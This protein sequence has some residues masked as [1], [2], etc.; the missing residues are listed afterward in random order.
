MRKLL[1]FIMIS[2]VVTV[3]VANYAFFSRSGLMMKGQEL[4]FTVYG[5]DLKT[6]VLTIRELKNES[7]LLSKLIG[8]GEQKEISSNLGAV[9]LRRAYTPTKDWETF[10]LRFDRL[11]LYYASLTSRDER[12]KEILLDETFLVITDLEAVHFTD[13]EKTILCVMRQNG[14]FVSGAKVF[15]YEDS[16]LVFETQ[17]NPAGIA[18]CE[19]ACDFFYVQKETCT[20]GE[21]YF[22]YKEEYADEKLFLF[23][24]R[25]I[26]K[27]NDTVRFRGQLFS[28]R[29][30]LYEA[31]GKS[32]VSV[33]VK[34]SKNNELYR[35]SLITDELGGFFDEFKLPETAS[36]GVYN[37]TVFH[38]DKS[39]YNSFVVEEYR[40]PEYKISI[41]VPEEPLF[42]GKVVRFEIFVRY[43][44][45]QPVARAQVAYY[46]HAKPFYEEPF[47]AHRGLDLTDEEGKLIVEVKTEEGF[48]GY[49]TIEVIA[50]DESQRQVE[51]TE[52]VRVWAD[53]VKIELERDEIW[54]SPGESVK[55]AAFVTKVSGEPVEG[56]LTVKIDTIQQTVPVTEGKAVF[57]FLPS[58]SKTYQIELM[59]GKAKQ[60]LYVHAYGKGYK[61]SELTMLCPE[62][63]VQPGQTIQVDLIS[64]HRATGLLTLIAEK[65]YEAIPI[66]F[67]DTI[68]ITLRVSEDVVERNLFIVFLGFE[69]GRQVEK[70]QIISVRR[71]TNVSKLKVS[72]DKSQY[73]PGEMATLLIE[74]E[75]NN[76]CLALIDEAIYAMLRRDPPDLEEF[77][78]PE[79]TYPS[80]SYGFAYTWRL[81]SLRD[82]LYARLVSK[83]TSFEDFKRNAVMEKI[84]VREYFPDTALWIPSL[85]LEQGRTALRF[86]VPDNIT[87]FRTT[88]YGFSPCLFS[89]GSGSMIVSKSFY[90][91]PH[92][93]TFFRENDSVQI[94]A[95]VFNQTNESLKTRYWLE[96]PKNLR[97]VRPDASNEAYILPNLPITQKWLVQA[98]Q[99]S[100]PSTITLYAV[101]KF[102]DA[103]ALNVPVKPFAF[104]R[105]YYLLEKIE[106]VKRIEL[107][108][109]EYVQA[110]LKVLTSIVPMVKESIEKLIRYP[111]GCTE[112]TMSSFFPAVVATRLG[113]EFPKLNEIVQKGLVRLYNYQHPDGGWG[114]W[115][116]DES[117][118][119]MSA[120]VMEGLYQAVRA[121]YDVSKTVLERGIDYLRSN[122][123]GYGVYVLSLYGMK[124]ENFKPKDEIDFIFNALVSRDSLQRALTLLKQ[125]DKIAYLQLDFQDHFVSDV[126]L[127]SV[128]LRALLKWEKDSPLAA[129]LIN[130]LLSKKDSYF[131]YSTKDTSYSILALLEALPRLD[132][133][134]ISVRNNG[135]SFFLN[136]EAEISL[137]KGSLEIEGEGLVEV[138]VVYLERPISAVSEGLKIER[139]IHKRYELYLEEERQLIDAFIPLGTDLVPIR[140]KKVE[141][142]E[143][144]LC[145][146][147]FEYDEPKNFEYGG[148]KFSVRSNQLKLLNVIYNFEKLIA[149]SQII[150]A[151][152]ENN[153]ALICDTKN[154]SVT[155]HQ[156]V[157]DVAIVNSNVVLLKGKE[158]W[159]ND[160]FLMEVPEEIEE[161]SCS[162]REIL[163]KS[164]DSSYWVKKDSLVVL[165]FVA[166]VV[167][168]W[169]GERLV[170]SNV[171]FSGNDSYI[172][173][174]TFEIIFAK[175]TVK[176]EAGNIAKT[177]LK[178]EKNE[179]QYL[180]IE[181]FFASCAQVI[182]NYRE[183]NFSSEYLKF[184]YGWYRPWNAWYSAHELHEDRIAF[185][186]MFSRGDTFS[187]VW[188]VTTD[189][190]YQ[191]LPA[192]AYSMY[193]QGLYSHSD[194]CVL[195]IG[196]DG[197]DL[198]HQ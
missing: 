139:Y 31:L 112:Q 198:D 68:S 121:G 10:S 185:F 63:I 192:R 105:E 193:K 81:Y 153:A 165:P 156:D 174:G 39:Y 113:L 35:K 22:P 125:S 103:I 187:Y 101:S 1:F 2:I 66:D 3:A 98:V 118:P 43:F 108:K 36:V 104:E 136:T 47:L 159:L 107:P 51:E 120:Y 94:G 91:R 155:I 191:L 184:D 61:P 178:L 146:F 176:L 84:N 16:R 79:N 142:E 96:I 93:P 189:G 135:K 163:L 124:H 30:N 26:Y 119:M 134:N 70:S 87:T 183:R 60:R 117:H 4:K 182:T 64:P 11:G 90:V 37:L 175:E 38:A 131:W 161:L 143:T 20:F 12:G 188:R 168:Y 9:V 180:I 54:T 52:S 62:T 106:G 34:D 130:Y 5:M 102:T 27:P 24:D 78:Y 40:K 77:L 48:D 99:P 25:P 58:Q 32:S 132:S 15:F 154:K 14:G 86:K 141:P 196:M 157:K 169:D 170:A 29:G 149:S 115:E 8:V 6:V 190:I 162:D 75:A 151:K 73:E 145:V 128:L 111:Y 28:K 44:N 148:V 42:S 171:K 109:G 85:K 46:I 181:D 164:R 56:T 100:D 95:T 59:F 23:T 122:P 41:R 18:I 110:K 83:E 114:W 116:K 80:V 13:G 45:E 97:L 33:V 195:Y 160:I 55:I 71:Q 166:R 140:I 150:V 197:E 133:P 173:E 167:H 92:L 74:G 172:G 158:L 57:T 123:T 50:T 179:G 186:A 19:T 65:I 89:Q 21:I 72:F 82:T 127:C 7:I 49:Y 138:H 152:L 194:P 88:V 129:K 147:A 76:I 126:Q 144:A 67:V 137:D 17:T 53:D 69:N 177:V